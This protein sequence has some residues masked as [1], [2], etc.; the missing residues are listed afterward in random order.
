M[1]RDAD[2]RV[3]LDTYPDARPA[4]RMSY[5]AFLDVPWRFY[6]WAIA[7]T[8]LAVWV[9]TT[10]MPPADL[11]G[12]VEL[13]VYAVTFG[14]GVAY[15]GVKRRPDGRPVWRAILEAV[16]T[17]GRARVQGRREV[18]TWARTEPTAVRRVASRAAAGT[19]AAARDLDRRLKERAS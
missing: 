1:N 14:A 13:G 4:D 12:L 8:L 6:P 18:V 9:L 17:R 3:I 10:V 2:G 7:G 15:L 5:S 11:A 16:T 19:S